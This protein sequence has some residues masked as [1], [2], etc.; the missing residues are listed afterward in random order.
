MA[1][2]RANKTAGLRDDETM[3]RR[4][5]EI[6]RRRDSGTTGRRDHET[7]RRRD[8]GTTRL[9][10]DETTRRRDRETAEKHRRS[11]AFSVVLSRAGQCVAVR[12]SARQCVA[13]WRESG[14]DVVPSRSLA[15]WGCTW[16]TS[17]F[18]RTSL[19]PQ[20]RRYH[21][22]GLVSEGCRVLHSAKMPSMG[23]T[24]AYVPLTAFFVRGRN[25]PLIT[26]ST[27]V[28]PQNTPT[29]LPFNAIY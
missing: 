7:T 9:R 19:V 20:M 14:A 12:G 24:K 21:V 22:K 2:K 15:G 4:D 23:S 26:P 16:R 10:D 8:C 17:P 6:T 1:G 11:Q 3:R 27:P 13:A 25:R 18:R 29:Q 28:Q 5:D